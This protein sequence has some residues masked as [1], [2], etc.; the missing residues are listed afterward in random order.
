MP[1]AEGRKLLQELQDHA[2]TRAPGCQHHW[3]DHDVLV[4][5]DASVQHKA[6]G[7]FRLGEPR[8]FWRV[9]DRGRTTGMRH[10]EHEWRLCAI[11]AN[12]FRP[13][14][15]HAGNACR[16]RA[17]GSPRVP[18]PCALPRDRFARLIEIAEAAATSKAATEV[19]EGLD[20]L[21]AGLAAD[22]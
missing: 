1:I 8:R 20:L 16:A 10:V 18:R 6:G 2:E 5:D 7:N 22:E 21:L 11:R 3:R 12:S 15:R 13:A 4:W 14:P 19:H 9:H 17:A